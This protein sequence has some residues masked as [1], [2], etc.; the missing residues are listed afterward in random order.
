MI[1]NRL[2]K[3][4]SQ[5]QPHVQRA[6]QF[7]RNNRLNAPISRQLKRL[8]LSFLHLTS[9]LFRRLIFRLK[10]LLKRRFTGA[11][12]ADEYPYPFTGPIA[13]RSFLKQHILHIIA[14]LLLAISA[15]FII[16]FFVPVSVSFEG[17]IISRQVSFTNR[18]QRNQ[19]LIN[20]M[21]SISRLEI[22]GLQANPVT[23]WGEFRTDDDTEDINELNEV[24]MT[25]PSPDS[26]LIFETGDPDNPSQLEI[27]S[28]R[29]PPGTQVR[30]L[31]YDPERHQLSLSLN[32]PK[33]ETPKAETPEEDTPEEDNPGIRVQL[34]L[35]GN[36]LQ[37][38]A[39]YVRSPQLQSLP[40]DNGMIEETEIFDY[41]QEQFSWTPFSTELNLFFPNEITLYIDLPDLQGRDYQDWFWGGFEV[42]DVDFTYN[43]TT[44]NVPDELVRSTILEGQIKFLN[45]DL[46][47]ESEQFLVLPSS[48]KIQRIPRLQLHP[49][50][51]AGLQVRLQG[52]TNEVAVGLDPDFPVRR[53]KSNFW[54]QRLSRELITVLLTV[55][56]VMI[57]YLIPWLFT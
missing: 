53:L 14:L 12:L 20:S 45:E 32:P 31:A 39:E 46:L 41:N 1:P 42:T 6:V 8:R 44:A 5:C 52:K 43:A 56:S 55:C 49:D 50:S 17:N 2:R 33:A 4:W 57:G 47:L 7:A 24:E 51:P 23:L 21:R 48:S 26:K 29:L 22:E 34:A 37:V 3:C 36:P 40:S 13:V 30:Y 54:E 15:V 35:G 27:Q 38:I 25:L 28:L 18:V 11:K 10:T 16:A 19:L 9:T